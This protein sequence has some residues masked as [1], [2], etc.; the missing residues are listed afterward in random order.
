[1]ILRPIFPDQLTEDLPSLRDLD[2]RRDILVMSE[3]GWSLSDRPHHPKKI[4]FLLA[5]Q[6]HFANL[7]R[8]KGYTVL[9]QDWEASPLAITLSDYIASILKTFKQAPDKIVVTNPSAV[10]CQHDLL[11]WAQRYGIPV[12]ILDDDR[13]YCTQKDFD[14][15]A[16][17][18]SVFRMEFFYRMLR[19]RENILMQ[20]NG[21][22]EGGLW[23]YDAQNRQPAKNCPPSYQTYHQEPDQITADVL[24]M[25]KKTVTTH[26]GA[27]EPF[28]FAVTRQGALQALRLF[29]TQR[30]RFFGDYQ[31][32]MRDDDPWLYH[33]HISLYLNA[34]LLTARECVAAALEAYEQK[35]A[36]LN[37]T[38]GFV[39]QILGWREFVRGLYG[40]YQ[41]L[42]QPMNALE[43]HRKLPHI[44]WGGAT[45]MRCMQRC[46]QDTH[47]NAYAHH[48]QRLMVLGNFALLAGI[49]PAEVDSWYLLVYADAYEWVEQPNV[50]GMILWA[51][52][53]L[54]ASKPY[55][56]SGAYIN[57]MSNYCHSCY[58][59]VSDKN[60]PR[61]CPFHSLYWAF[62]IRHEKRFRS[63]PRM[64]MIYQSLDKMDAAKKQ[65]YI[66]KA[67]AFLEAIEH[68]QEV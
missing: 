5:A 29:I 45:K 7:W 59:S 38:E 31:D 20:M 19:Q 53:G 6:R 48:I 62:L 22:P 36:P 39:R 26:F 44:Y 50:L 2:P 37:A 25:L 63:N 55:A 32:V 21:Q 15:W 40:H 42:P 51:D 54:L 56:A 24:A 8:S 14:I 58:Y 68:G 12:T 61:A 43:A 3:R 49:D 28:H 60:S 4:I 66:T 34:G 1:M 47:D 67:T 35:I 33:S 10:P 57:K 30:L 9:L 41:K 13:F 23:N 18:R 65:L 64:A 46:V 11:L 52:G 16:Q 17:G 27:L